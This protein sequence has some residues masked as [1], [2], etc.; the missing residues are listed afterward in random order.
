MKIAVF[1]TKAYDRQALLLANQR[2]NHELVF[3]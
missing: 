1:D 2:F 3:F